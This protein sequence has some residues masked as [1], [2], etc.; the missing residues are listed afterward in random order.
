MDASTKKHFKKTA[1]EFIEVMTQ[2][3]NQCVI[4][5]DVDKLGRMVKHVEMLTGYEVIESLKAKGLHD[6]IRAL[7][8][9]AGRMETC[10]S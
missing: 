6:E 5:E 2:Y 7:C 8:D 9:K 3:V 1:N 10:S 4:L